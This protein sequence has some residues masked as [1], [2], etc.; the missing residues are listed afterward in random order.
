MILSNLV[1]ARLDLMGPIL[2]EGIQMDDFVA[3][4]ILPALGVDKRLGAIPSF[5][6]TND[7]ILNVKHSPKTA[8]S[9]VLSRTSVKSFAC[10]EN[11]LKSP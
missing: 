10:N 11:G 3:H 9:R 2:F 4:Q 5:L 7:Q 6:F 8:F 1:Q